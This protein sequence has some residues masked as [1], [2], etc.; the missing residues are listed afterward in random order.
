[1]NS[2]LSKQAAAILI[3]AAVLTGIYK[4]TGSIDGASVAWA[5]VVEQLNKYEKYKCRQR[6]V[7]ENGP[8]HPTMDIYHWNLSLRRQEVEDG[9]IHVIDMQNTDAITVELNPDK[10]K[11][12]VTKLLG[13]GPRKDP[14]IIDMVK[15]FEQVSTE[16]LGTKK[17]DGRTLV[18]FHHQP[19]EHNDF[20]VWVDAQTKLPVE[21]ELKD[22]TAGQT[23]YLDRFE[24]D[25]N[26]PESAFST[27]VPAGY[28]IKTYTQ[29]YR[30]PAA[31]SISP[32]EIAG[33]LGHSAYNIENLSWAD[34]TI[35]LEMTDPLGAKF[36]VFV[37]AVRADDGSTLLIDQ[38]Q[39]T[40]I[41]VMVWVP[42]QDMVLETNGVKC[43]T[44]PNGS[45]YAE[46]YLKGLADAAPDFFSSSQIG[47]EKFTRMLAMPDNAVLGL[48]ST[49]E[50][51]DE[52][53]KELAASLIK[54]EP[55]N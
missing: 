26:L 40:T 41:D 22:P 44:H 43:Y 39:Y 38:S 8:E 32:E 35:C 29:D 50:L 48:V 28:E 34:K 3:I 37:I 15:R 18:G 13:F 31:K 53:L 4:I 14:D 46:Y 54:I 23:I 27:E 12:V 30:S 20:T 19:N 52:R 6:V 25:F 10:K 11:A 51:T 24:F 36:R 7:R 16:R 2:P 45:L 1:M 21:I 47:E 49:K 42:K 5:Q 33:K 55:A 9:S 17:Q